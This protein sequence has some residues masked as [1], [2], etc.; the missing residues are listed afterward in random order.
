[1]AIAADDGG[2][3]KGRDEPLIEGCKAHPSRRGS[4]YDLVNCLGCC[5]MSLEG[6]DTSPCSLGAEATLSTR[7]LSLLRW[8]DH[9][10][11]AAWCMG[12]RWLVIPYDRNGR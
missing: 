3:K 8:T 4:S 1:M 2:M 7:Y 10:A 11:N 12:R 6:Y 5:S 9:N